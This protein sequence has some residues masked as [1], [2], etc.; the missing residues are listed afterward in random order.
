MTKGVKTMTTSIQSIQ[1]I[2]GKMQAALDDPT[3]ADRPE[4]TH[5]LQQQRGRLN[6]G[7]YGTEL[8]HLQ[9]LL[10]RYALTHAFDVPSSVQRLNVELIRQLRGFDV[11]LATQ[12]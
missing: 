11:L 9:G 6:S 4:L 1:V 8:R 5:L 3:V 12:R 7:D 10:S 2:L